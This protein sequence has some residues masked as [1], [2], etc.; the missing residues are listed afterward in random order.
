MRGIR[1]GV[2]V[3]GSF[4]QHDLNKYVWLAGRE[5]KISYVVLISPQGLDTGG[6]N[7]VT[8]AQAKAA[9]TH[10]GDNTQELNQKS[11]LMGD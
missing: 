8:A 1:N 7:A 2:G 4:E 5:Q 11:F 10:S 3:R 9:Y 6:A